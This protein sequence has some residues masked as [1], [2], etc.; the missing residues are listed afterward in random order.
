[1][2]GSARC[3]LNG[4]TEREIINLGECVYD[5]KGIDKYHLRIFHC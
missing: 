5:P 3:N 2:L 4:K 1:M